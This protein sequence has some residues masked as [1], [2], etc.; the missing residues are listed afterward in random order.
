MNLFIKGHLT[1]EEGCERRESWD[2]GWHAA[3]VTLLQKKVLH[4]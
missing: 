4:M 3:E 1:K 2:V